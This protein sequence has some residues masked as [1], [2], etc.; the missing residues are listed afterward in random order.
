[1]IFKGCYGQIFGTIVGA[2]PIEMMHDFVLGKFSAEDSFH[3]NPVFKLV[4]L[5]ANAKVYV[6][7]LGLHPAARPSVVIGSVSR[8]CLG[9]SDSYT[10]CFKLRFDSS[11]GN[12]KFLCDLTHIKTGKVQRNDLVFRSLCVTFPFGFTR[13][14]KFPHALGHG[15]LRHAKSLGD[16]VLRLSGR[17]QF[18]YQ[19]AVTDNLCRVHMW[20]I[21]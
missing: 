10:R 2:N 7:A 4:L 5:W 16:F 15:G 12:A 19:R 17:I 14:A 1:M 21:A 6:A 3:N 18:F 8:G 11:W 13:D 9:W 20:S